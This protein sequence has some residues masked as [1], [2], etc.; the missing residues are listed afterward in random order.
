MNITVLKQEILDKKLRP[1]YVF[2]GDELVLQDIY[3]DEIAKVSGLDKLRI[4]YLSNV[5]SKLSVK[6]LIKTKPKLYIIRN[7]DIY[8]K[9]E[10]VWDKVIS[11]KGQKGNIIILLYSNLDKRGKF[12]KAHEDILTEFNFIGKSILSARLQAITKW[13]IQYCDDL[14]T[15]C[16]CNYGR[17]KNELYKLGVLANVLKSNLTTAYLYAK[18]HN[19][20]HEEIGDII[21]D[22]TNAIIERN[23][24]LSYKLLSQI[25][26]TDEG[27]IKLLSVLYNSFRNI[28]IVQSTP[29]KERTE[30]IL[31]LTKGQ[32]YVT[33]QKCDRYTLS[34]L[35]QIIKTIQK[36]EKGIKTGTV[37]V[38]F[39][40]E[41]LMG[42]VL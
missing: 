3:I 5:Y 6:T 31:G 40:M 42:E 9:E 7:D 15:T 38:N 29:Q 27:P 2:C 30:E 37:D 10:K 25:T 8:Y 17:I 20:I 21:F 19:M 26:K 16:G 36:L 11:G 22:F 32:I 13:P 28:L 35:V 33:S 39:A 23:V 14:V 24:T 18:K 4:E 41:Y 12:Y 34:E 1:T